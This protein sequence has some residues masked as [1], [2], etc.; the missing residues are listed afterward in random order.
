M[1]VRYEM[2][3][4][5]NNM[6]FRSGAGGQYPLIKTTTSPKIINGY[7]QK[8]T[9][10]KGLTVVSVGTTD[11]WLHVT[12]IEGV[13]VDGY[14]AQIYNGVKY[15]T[16]ETFPIPD[17]ALKQA[18]IFVTIVPHFEDGSVGIAE[19]YYPVLV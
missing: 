16:I 11:K 19:D 18:I 12:S 17:P 13:S 6:G 1:P 9:V 15:C 3:S 5:T 2:V 14:V 8:N 10:M 7:V 4:T